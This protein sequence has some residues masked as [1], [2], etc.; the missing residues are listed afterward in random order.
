MSER[1]KLDVKELGSITAEIKRLQALI[2]PLRKRKITIESNILNYMTQTGPKGLTAIHTN[3]V[4]ILAVE[5]KGRDRLTKSEKDTAAIQLL[6]QSGVRN[7][8]HT[9]K[10]LQETTKGKENITKTIK[11][12]DRF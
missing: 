6:Q 8:N 7:A 10:V 12:T 2:V 5:K 3:T 4:Q 11:I 9:Y 1:I